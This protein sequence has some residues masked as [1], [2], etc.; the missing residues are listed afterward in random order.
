MP[1]DTFVFNQGMA[2]TQF[3]SILFLAQADAT[4]KKDKRFFIAVVLNDPNQK[5][6]EVAYLTMESLK[7]DINRYQIERNAWL[8]ANKQSPSSNIYG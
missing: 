7:A 5:A 4:S 1:V 8:L 2:I 6:F 3:E